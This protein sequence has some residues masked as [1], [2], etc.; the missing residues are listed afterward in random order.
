MEL[1]NGH[2][3]KPE[4]EDRLSILPDDI[5]LSILGRVS[6]TTAAR[7][8]V[9]STRWKHLP[10]LLPEL[11]IDAK[12]FL[13]APHPTRSLLATRRCG[14]TT[15]SRLQLKFYLLNNYSDVIG[16][17]ISEAVDT[18]TVKDLD[19]DIIDEKE[20]N[21]CTDEDMLQQASSVSS[22][23]SAYP[24]MLHCLTKLSLY[25]ICFADWDMNHLLFDCCKQL[26]HLYISNCD[27]VGEF[28][29]WKIDAPDS[30]LRPPLERGLSV[31]ELFFCLV[32]R[33]DILCLPNLE[34]LVWD[35]WL[36][37]N[38]PLSLG[39]V[40]SLQELCLI[41]AA[42]V[43]Y[44]GFNLSEV[45]SKTTAIRSLTLSFQG[46]RIWIQP[47]GKQLCS[48]FN[49][50]RKLSVHDIFIEFDML[51]M[52][53]LLEAAPSVE[54]LD[55]E[56][57]EH[58]CVMDNERR[59][60]TFGERT[61]PSWK[62]AEFTSSKEW[63]LKQVHIIG[64]SPMEQLLEFIKAVMD[65]APKLHSFVVKDHQP[66]DYCEKMGAL[67]VLKDYQQNAYSRRAKKSKT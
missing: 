8:S 66:C 60:L 50:L 7:T 40:P 48:A 38:S 58:P 56:I 19:L 13:P 16:P 11:T 59:R 64:F 30:K 55:I 14:Y 33:L 29:T 9:L 2:G 36:S 1:N 6:I 25:N 20:P 39:V 46:E 65:R 63:L 28:L 47:E 3:Q 12:E 34:R 37:Q 45:L 4:D 23:F 62:M 41:S 24:S 54:I 43:E 52:M 57:W 61:N 26:R 44:K 32:E 17:L 18:R 67:L 51:W 42:P 49:K 10:W 22:F 15:I 35:T 31:L 21:D 5:L 27:T 53:V